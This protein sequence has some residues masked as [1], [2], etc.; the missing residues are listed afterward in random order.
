MGSL[1]EKEQKYGKSVPVITQ[2]FASPT[3]RPGET[4][5]VYLKASDT[6]GDMKNFY[7]TIFQPGVGP[8]P[9]SI[10]KIKEGDTKD[11]SGYLYLYTGN[12]PAMNFVNLILTVQIQ[13]KAGHFSAPAV[14]PLAFNLGSVQRT[15]PSGT[16]QEKDLGPIIFILR[17]SLGDGDSSG[18]E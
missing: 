2:S 3:V 18:F 1:E 17:A 14:F 10:T 8:Y 9:L 13:D 6:D 5:K 4:W 16:F 12:E 11:L 7:A 15:P